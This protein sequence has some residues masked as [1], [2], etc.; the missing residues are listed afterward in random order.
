MAS[1]LDIS[2]FKMLDIFYTYFRNFITN[3]SGNKLQKRIFLFEKEKVPT[4]DLSCFQFLL[5]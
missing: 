1:N 2:D 3:L 4:L 5:T